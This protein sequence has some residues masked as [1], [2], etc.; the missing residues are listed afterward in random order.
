MCMHSEKLRGT[1][2]ENV[3]SMMIFIVEKGQNGRIYKLVF[4]VERD[5]MGECICHE[6]LTVSQLNDLKHFI[7]HIHISIN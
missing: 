2:W 7:L 6:I 1:K 3:F 4:T 5:K